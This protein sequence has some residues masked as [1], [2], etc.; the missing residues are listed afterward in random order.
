MEQT[1]PTTPLSPV[2]PVSPGN[3]WARLVKQFSKF[4][5]VG[6]INTGIDFA[7][8][9]ALM[10]LSDIRSGLGLFVLNCVSFSV[11]VVNSYFMNRR[12][13][14]REAAVGIADKNNAVQFSQFFVVSVI[15]IVINGSVLTLIA[16]YIPAPFGL[17]QQLWANVAKLFAT[18][19]SLV[20]NFL[21]Y[22]FI[23]FKK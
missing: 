16:T 10:Y 22:K 2:T 17:N 15:G 3:R 18:G 7:V 12:W 19:A 14:F 20:W 21:G 11:A 8:L 1:V 4:V 5:I 13:T 9:N 6:G 23:V